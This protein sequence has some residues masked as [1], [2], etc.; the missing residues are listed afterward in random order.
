[1]PDIPLTK[2]DIDCFFELG[3]LAVEAIFK[4]Q[5]ISVIYRKNYVN[6]ESGHIGI[7]NAAPMAIAKKS[8]VDGVVKGDIIE[9]ET[10][11]FLITN[12]Q[13]NS[14]YYIKLFLEAE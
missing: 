14:E 4:G 9:I 2:E 11:N 10:E 13:P 6:M 3:E 8:D 1:M 5:S 7:S 12:V